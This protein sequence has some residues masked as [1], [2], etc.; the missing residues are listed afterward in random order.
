MQL[1]TTTI[2]IIYAAAEHFTYPAASYY[3]RASWTIR[4]NTF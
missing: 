4:R 3:K 1:A 2:I